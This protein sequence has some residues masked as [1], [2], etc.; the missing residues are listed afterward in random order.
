MRRVLSYLFSGF[1]VAAA[2]IAL[3][4]CA[5]AHHFP[6]TYVSRPAGVRSV[7]IYRPRFTGIPDGVVP[8]RGGG[9]FYYESGNSSSADG[10]GVESGVVTRAG[11]LHEYL[12]RTKNQFESV[13]LGSD[14]VLWATSILDNRSWPP[15]WHSAIEQVGPAR[16][17]IALRIPDQFGYARKLAMGPD[18]AWWFALPDV[19]AIGRATPS[20]RLSLKAVSKSMKPDDIAFDSS[21][22]LYAAETR[23]NSVVKI[24]PSGK[25]TLFRVGGA[26][27]EI[28]SLAGGVHGDVWFTESSPDRIGHITSTGRVEAFTVG[29]N[30]VLYAIAVGGRF[31]LVCRPERRRKALPSHSPPQYRPTTQFE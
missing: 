4:S 26:S 20:G 29:S 17:S 6:A 12:V 30:V 15:V 23:G 27:A 1:C 7:T 28:G 31:R 5:F 14:G 8:L 18:G 16:S 11:A 25:R 24:S 2:P 3:L 19:H 21:G 13:T 10:T 9:A 22:N